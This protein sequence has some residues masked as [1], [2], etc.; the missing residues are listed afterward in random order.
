MGADTFVFSRLRQGADRILDWSRA[1]GDHL[2][3]DASGFGSDVPAVTAAVANMVIAAGAGAIASQ[4]S[5]QFILRS[6]TG[7][8][9]YDDDGTGGHAAVLIVRLMLSGHP[10]STLSAG[11]FDI[12]A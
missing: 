2:R 7:Q 9:F 6:D 3:I 5:A 10:A 8:L 1:E 11:D 12:V 4:A